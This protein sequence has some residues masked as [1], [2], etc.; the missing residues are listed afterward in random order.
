MS[1][2]EFIYHNRTL[3]VNL[4]GDYNRRSIT[5]LKNKLYS[6]IEQYGINDIVIDKKLT[7]NIDNNAF[8]DMLDD[9]DV[10]YGGHLIVEE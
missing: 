3:F 4:S 7:A 9:Y 2:S 1:K 10:R 5:S 8:Y 6:I